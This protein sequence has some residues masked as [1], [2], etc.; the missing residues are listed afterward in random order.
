MNRFQIGALALALSVGVGLG[1]C[2]NRQQGGAVLGGVAGGVLGSTV[3]QGSGKTA[4]IVA[5]TLLGAYVG[6]EIGRQMDEND[7][8][9][10]REALEYSRT[11]ETV[12]WH[13]PD[14][15]NDYAVTPIRTYQTAQ[16]PCREY[17]TKARIGGK[18]EEV[19]GTACRQP[20]GSW[21]TV[22]K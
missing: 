21:K 22:S 8:R 10:A 5:G 20:D 13:N 2:A 14:S 11:D 19:Y 3:G 9:R 16:G 4:A 1:G 6:S 12:R 18:T 7:R 17:I 15:G